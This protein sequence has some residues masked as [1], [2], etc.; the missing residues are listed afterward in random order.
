MQHNDSRERKLARY[1]PT[2]HLS[3]VRE[4]M[5]RFFDDDFFRFPMF[6]SLVFS[7]DAM[8]SVLYPK[9]D[10][11]ENEKEITVTANVPG[12][13]AE[14]ISIEVDDDTL[15]ISGKIEKEKKE[16]KEGETFYRYEREYGEFRREFVLPSKVNK[17]AVKATTKNGV[18]T[19]VL[20]KIAS[21]SR[22]KVEV[23]EN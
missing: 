1:E 18:L 10:I 12:L 5:E 3:P 21:E 13:S 23:K 2:R 11:S 16:G 20:P 17:D 4:M 14:H 15:T 7:N 22:K 19:I 8:R 6:P 9:V